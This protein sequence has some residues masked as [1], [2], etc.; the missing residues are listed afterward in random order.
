MGGGPCL[1]SHSGPQIPE[2]QGRALPTA[3]TLLAW[4]HSALTATIRPQLPW[5]W[6]K[7]A[8]CS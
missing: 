6:T 3:A 7:P 8:P 4:L 2:D 5:G 1:D